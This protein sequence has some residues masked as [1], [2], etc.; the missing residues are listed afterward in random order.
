MSKRTVTFVKRVYPPIPKSPLIRF[1][2]SA[3]DDSSCST[4][5]YCP[6]SPI[7][8]SPNI[9]DTA[10]AVCFSYGYRNVCCIPDYYNDDEDSTSTA[11]PS[12]R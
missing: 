8:S 10:C 7:P 11:A 3:D 4:I 1:D 9:T 2:Y 6:E 5:V 12:A